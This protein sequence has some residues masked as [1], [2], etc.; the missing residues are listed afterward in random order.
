M[1]GVVIVQFSCKHATY[2]FV[3]VFGF[4]ILQHEQATLA[5]DDDFHHFIARRCSG[6]RVNTTI[7]FTCVLF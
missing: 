6:T 1:I 7:G 2:F 3:V 5:F 4:V